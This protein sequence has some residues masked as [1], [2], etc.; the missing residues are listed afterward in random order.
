MKTIKLAVS[1]LMLLLN[2]SI[3]KAQTWYFGSGA[4]INFNG[5]SVSLSEGSPIN[6][7]E[8]CSIVSDKDGNVIFYTDGRTVW[9]KYHLPLINGTGL[10][11]NSSATQSA[12]IIPIP[13]TSCKIFYFYGRCCRTRFAKWPALQR[14]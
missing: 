6:T 12:L 3:I 11:G 13:N 1:I 5:A 4:G 14:S 10:L 7:S 8:G 9:S 2:V